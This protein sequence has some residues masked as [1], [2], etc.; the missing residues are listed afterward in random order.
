MDQALLTLL[1]KKDFAYITVKEICERAGVN[2]STFYLHYETLGDLLSES[3]EYMNAQF[4]A[5]MKQD[6][7][8]M[9]AKLRE[10]PM[11]ELYFLTPEYL[12]PY[13][14]YIRE[15]KNLFLTTLKNAK[16]FRLEESYDK[17]FRSVF[18]PILERHR[19]NAESREYLMAFY[20][21]GLMGIII[22]WLREDCRESVEEIMK[23]MQ[24][25][26]QWK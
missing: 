1:E 5:Y 7:E 19:I 18:A 3:V 11:D 2:R 17:M 25:C 20:I 16:M 8:T 23:I 14:N 21:Q 24:A 9:V 10:C 12:V 15:H 13:L 26:A 6:A 4:L 22:K